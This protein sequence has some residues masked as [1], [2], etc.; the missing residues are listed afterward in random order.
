MNES[1]FDHAHIDTAVMVKSQNQS[2][3]YINARIIV[4]L[5]F[6]V[7]VCDIIRAVH[8]THMLVYLKQC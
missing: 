1:A 4:F 5:K 8:H 3:T 2:V 7:I 6:V